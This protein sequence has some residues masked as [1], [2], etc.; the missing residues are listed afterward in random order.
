MDIVC[1]LVKS[2]S[3]ILQKKKKGISLTRV[4][5][6]QLSIGRIKRRESSIV[7]RLRI[8]DTLGNCMSDLI[9]GG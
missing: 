6:D 5:R 8:D 4:D 2:S 1:E 9:I 3:D 7:L